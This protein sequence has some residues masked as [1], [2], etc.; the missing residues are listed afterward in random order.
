MAAAAEIIDK[1]VLRNGLNPWEERSA[2]VP[3]VALQVQ[4]EQGLLHDILDILKTQPISGKA[5]I[6]HAAQH[7][8]KLV[9]Q[10]VIGCP[11][12]TIGRPHQVSP[13]KLPIGH[14][15]TSPLRTC[16]PRRYSRV[17]SHHGPNRQSTKP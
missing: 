7:G 16:H 15:P 12:I 3:C 14:S 4:S 6:D 11:V 10:A 8:R 1:L 9:Q 17:A 13:T 5:A 2:I